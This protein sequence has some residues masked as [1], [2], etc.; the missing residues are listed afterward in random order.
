MSSNEKRVYTIFHCPPLS[1]VS[2][3]ML[4]ITVV[5]HSLEA[6][7]FPLTHAQKVNSS[8]MLCHNA[9]IIHLTSPHHIGILSYHKEVVG[10]QYNNFER[11]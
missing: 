3:S 4:R 9:D 6:E 1:M 8:I 11:K 7:I 2:L 10:V 5:S